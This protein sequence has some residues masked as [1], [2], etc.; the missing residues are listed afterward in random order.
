MFSQ[1]A[2]QPSA[3]F[4][5]WVRLAQTTGRSSVVRFQSDGS[6]DGPP[7]LTDHREPITAHFH[8]LSKIR[9]Q[10]AARSGQR[11]SAGPVG[12]IT[13]H[14]VRQEAAGAERGVGKG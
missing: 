13:R 6:A 1:N 12:D 10:R 4:R 2:L 7:V 5:I 11:I 8:W 3:G 9:G 14:R